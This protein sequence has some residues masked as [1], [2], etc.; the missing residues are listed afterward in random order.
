MES[1]LVSL[2]SASV[3]RSR[4][5]GV[6]SPAIS[7]VVPI[8]N[9]RAVL[10]EL[11]RRL[12]GVLTE[13]TPTFEI[14]LVNDGSSDRSWDKVVELTRTYPSVRGLNLMRNYGQHNALLAG[15]RA[16]RHGVIV[17]LDD[18][19]QNPPEEIPRLLD[20]LARGY[21]VVYGTPRRGQR[22]MLRTLATHVTKL[23]LQNA[24]GIEHARQV[25]TFRA[26]HARVRDAFANAQSGVVAIDVL[27][28]WGATR[29]S[30]VAVDHEPRKIGASTYTFW[31][32]VT[33]TLN[34][35]TGFSILPLQFASIV[36]FAF[37]LFGLAVLAF[38]I[39]RY[40]IAG[41]SVPG[42]PFLASIIAIFSGAQLFALGVIGEYL[43]RV[44]VRMM[45]RPTYVVREDTESPPG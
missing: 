41:G 19:L 20:E 18:D 14:V 40:L 2:E 32:L 44:H 17:T 3:K 36:G 39:G 34:M 24:L 43:A 7:A 13:L 4:A 27:L 12:E 6:S 23:T 33:I 8:Y 21:D 16:A 10:D 35:V 15:I 30:A 1:P 22:G 5:A 26:F 45:G 42:I 28:T 38:V 9:S 29:F 31:K 11:V 25:S 37:T